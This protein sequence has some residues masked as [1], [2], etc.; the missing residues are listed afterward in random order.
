MT[1]WSAGGV[2]DDGLLMLIGLAMVHLFRGS[3]LARDQGNGQ[4]KRSH[5]ARK[6]R[7]G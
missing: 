3:L 4:V 7:K 5:M 6:Q 1:L 2:F